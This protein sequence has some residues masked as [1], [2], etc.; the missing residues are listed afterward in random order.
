M[1][2]LELPYPSHS[3][4]SSVNC[5]ELT[6]QIF[7]G[8][9]FVLSW[10][11]NVLLLYLIRKY[12]TSSIKLY[13]IVMKTSI[14]ADLYSATVQFLVQM[15]AEKV[16]EDQILAY[17]LDGYLPR[18]LK[19]IPFF[20]GTN[21]NYLLLFDYIGCYFTWG[22]NCVPFIYR[23][24]LLCWDK[25]MDKYA[26]GA[27]ICLLL[28]ISVATATCLILPSHAIFDYNHQMFEKP[29]PECVVNLA[30]FDELVNADRTFYLVLYH[31]YQKLIN[32][33]LLSFAVTFLISIRILIFLA[34]HSD[35]NKDRKRSNRQIT[36]VLLL[37]A[38][39]P[40]IVNGLPVLAMNF[41]ASYL[42]INME[43]TFKFYISSF[44]AA[45][46]LNPLIAILCISN[47]RRA[48][49]HKLGL[50]K[51]KRGPDTLFVRTISNVT[52]GK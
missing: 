45:P 25:R 41:V 48:L 16:G 9:L 1:T 44:M 4:Y 43:I 11:L 36:F 19:Y 31:I 14:Y 30:V 35:N 38:L 34:M 22:Y 3:N 24:V 26:F 12:T 28:A 37:Q 7:Y 52:V 21:M 20:Q 40:F 18:L 47:Y 49:L 6:P 23:Y 8:V 5:P 32:V 33:L 46:V 17:S 51:G 39:V 10:T 50:Y 2:T 29:D 15:R 27:L 13:T 42:K